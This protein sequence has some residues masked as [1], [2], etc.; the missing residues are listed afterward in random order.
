MAYVV[1][2]KYF[3]RDPAFDFEPKWQSELDLPTKETTS[4]L[5]NHGLRVP[6]ERFPKKAILVSSHKIKNDVVIAGIS[7]WAISER[8]RAIWDKF[9]PGLIEY[10]PVEVVRKNGEPINEHRYCYTNILN[11]VQTICWDGVEWTSVEPKTGYRYVDLPHEWALGKQKLGIKLDRSGHTDIHIW[12]ED[13]ADHMSSWVF[14]SDELA[15]A[16]R[17]ADITNLKYEH[18]EEDLCLPNLAMPSQGC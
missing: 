5:V 10:L 2:P 15:D 4:Y 7:K 9:A 12:H 8:V 16:M 3:S 11:R 6:P 14:M 17:A 1:T 13:N 18:I